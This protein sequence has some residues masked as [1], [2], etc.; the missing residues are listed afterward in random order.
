[1]RR[2]TPATVVVPRLVRGGDFVA[3]QDEHRLVVSVH[4]CLVR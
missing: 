2:L 3:G 1:M 4:R